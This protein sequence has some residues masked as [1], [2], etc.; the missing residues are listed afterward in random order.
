MPVMLFKL[1]GVPD[2]EAEEV[3][4]LLA[5]NNI[6]FYE[7]PAGRWGV[8]MEA[9]WLSDECLLDDARK[10]IAEYQQR[11]SRKVRQEYSDLKSQ[12]KAE[13]FLQRLAQRPAQ[14]ISYVAIILT[15]IYF[16][17]MPFIKLSSD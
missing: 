12:G 3:R 17:T 13:T 14:M 11:R 9:I 2:D 15:I 7:T 5:S 4:Q 1:R 10:L 8:S 16:V 6:Q